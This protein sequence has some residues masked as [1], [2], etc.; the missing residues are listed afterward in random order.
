MSVAIQGPAVFSETDQSTSSA[1]ISLTKYP[2]TR[3]VLN[4]I[5]A[6][7]KPHE[8]DSLNVDQELEDSR[9]T[10]ALVSRVVTLLQEEKEDE[11]KMYVKEAFQISDSMKDDALLDQNLLELMHKHRD[12]VSGVPFLFLTPIKRPTSRPS[13]RASS[14]SYRLA[15][16]RPD[17]PVSSPSSP[18][19]ISFRRPHTPVAS[20]LAGGTAIPVNILTQ[21]S[22]ASSS[23]MSSPHLLN[24]KAVE[25][26]PVTR[27]LS[28]SGSNS[29]SLGLAPRTDTPSPDL[30][31]HNSSRVTSN[32]AIAA[33][34]LPEASYLPTPPR[35]LTPSN[36]HR[37]SNI[38]EDYEAEFDPFSTKP[39]PTA[40]PFVPSGLSDPELPW[41]TSSNS[42]S[43]QS[44]SLETSSLIRPSD[45]DNLN[46]YDYP[47]NF[48][49][50]DFDFDTRDD[51]FG[52]Q[53]YEDQAELLTD[54]MTPFDVLTS[55]F[56]QSLSPE[57]LNEALEVN[58]YEFES[59]MAWLVDKALPQSSQSY[60]PLPSPRPQHL[61]GRIT[62]IPRDSAYM[63]RGGRGFSPGGRISPRYGSRPI[64]GP[65]RN[66]QLSHDLER[67]MCR[68][69][70]RGNCAKQ[71]NCEF[72]HHLP[73]DV[74]VS[75]LTTAMSGS[76]F[77]S[78]SRESTP[79]PDEFPTLGQHDMGRGRR[80]TYPQKG[81][82]PG[83]TRFASAVKMQPTSSQLG[84]R[85]EFQRMSNSNNS[86]L[87]ANMNGIPVPRPSP[88]FKLRPPTLL[89]TLLTGDSVNKL[90]MS[91]RHRAFQLGSARNA[92]LSRAADAWRRGDGAAVK[93][94]SREGHEL[95]AKMGGEAAE[96][97]NR[98]VKERV[99]L[100]AEAV[101]GRDASWSDDPRDRTDRGKVVAGGLG[102]ILGVASKEATL[103]KTTS[104][105]SPDERTETLL[106]LHGLHA[107]E[108]VDVLEKFLISL[109]KEGFCG[110]G[111]FLIGWP[112]V[113]GLKCL[114]AFVV[115]GEEKHT[116]TQDPGRGASRNRLASGV[117][118]WL[119]DWGYPWNEK[120]GIIVV[121]PLTHG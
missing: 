98:L 1:V 63:V 50:K 3:A 23:P 106:D 30:W 22:S 12:D 82:D 79:P 107:N 36:L 6:S 25:F 92:C 99:R 53:E 119:H 26:R 37:S 74:D 78:D 108:A 104:R 5:A 76:H 4:A 14:H 31:A 48:Q 81:Y 17:T 120:D 88:R 67:A 43:S 61:G 60:S 93:R 40:P 84:R 51:Y 62:V 38:D 29:S 16:I 9:I 46:G 15:P 13:S 111:E 42:T 54:G 7:T 72:L 45:A 57:Q 101:R 58:G 10:P 65:N 102:V 112:E 34:L 121:D 70:L 32:L 110:L 19:A 80:G 89:P 39:R 75:A 20:P 64:Q 91:Y 11:L 68:F 77:Q 115:V 27:P 117:R 94:F 35:A 21:P 2:H 18:L 118:A 114:S 85:P 56:G 24:A 69:W 95:N 83:R 28:A 103:D 87:F 86:P 97:A 109:E 49:P 96:A 100:A 59:A 8:K 44:N 105:L 116:G 71:E 52:S 73:R 33:P 41:S 90:Y 66:P 47:P 55:V 113:Q